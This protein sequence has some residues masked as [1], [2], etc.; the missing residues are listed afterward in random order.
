MTNGTNRV[1]LSLLLVLLASLSLLSPACR[2]DGVRDILREEA[3]SYRF[4][5]AGWHVR[6]LPA[7]LLSS[8][9]RIREAPPPGE[10]KALVEE[11]FT[12][13]SETAT[14]ERQLARAIALEGRS[15]LTDALEVEILETRL[16]YMSLARQVELIIEREVTDVLASQGFGLS[17]AGGHFIFPPVVF[18]FQPA[19]TMLVASPRDRIELLGYELLRP[20]MTIS[21][22]ELLE[23]GVAEHENL[24][25]LVVSPGGLASY[26]SIVDE[27]ASFYRTLY[28]VA[29]EWVHQYLIF[30]PLGRTWF[31]GGI[32]RQINET[33]ADIIGYEVADR[34]YRQYGYEPPPRTPPPTETG[35]DYAVELRE[36]RLVVGQLLQEGRV[37]EAERYMEER[38]Q[39]FV[40]EGYYIRKLNQAFFAIRDPYPLSP[41]S[42]SPIG[43]QLEELRYYYDTLGEFVVALRGLT[44]YDELLALLDEMRLGQA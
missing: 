28:V 43:E 2:S 23:E 40:Q 4:S 18:L 39:V 11:F 7:K 17:L 41:S 25:A 15:T 36:T 26:P 34:I 9:A 22:A 37:T 21:E 38:R 13:Q 44:T 27:G 19:P 10:R 30:Y 16:E 12:T 32:A 1:V 14:L 8:I 42:I 29:H 35:F 31:Q 3:S 20:A 24:C 5:L 33:V 6:N